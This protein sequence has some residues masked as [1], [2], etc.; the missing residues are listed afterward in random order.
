MENKIKNYND[1]KNENYDF[2]KTSRKT[3]KE[4]K[5][6]KIVTNILHQFTSFL[7]TNKFVIKKISK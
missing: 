1:N 7:S 6:K 2:D 3:C 5:K 4:K